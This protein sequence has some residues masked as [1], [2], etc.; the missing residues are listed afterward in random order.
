MAVQDH[1]IALPV[2][3]VSLYIGI[4]LGDMGLY[5]LGRLASEVQWARRLIPEQRQFSGREWLNR[6]VF[7]VVFIAR[8]L[9]GVRLPTYTTCGF[10]HASFARFALAATGATLIWTSALFAVSIRLGDVLMQHLG[11]WRWA[12]AAVFIL[13]IVVVG[14]LAAKAAQPS[15]EKAAQPSK[16][17]SAQSK[18]N[19]VAWT[20]TAAADQSQHEANATSPGDVTVEE[21]T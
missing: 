3:L 14:R 21:S 4:V 11:A 5:G 19:S 9:P 10:L 17:N 20:N 1:H 18:I 2:A 7:K 8:F 16:E 6:H 13:A 12:G 15:K